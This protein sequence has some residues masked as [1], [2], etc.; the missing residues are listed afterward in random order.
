[1]RAPQL[2]SH[3][4]C[5]PERPAAPAPVGER[6]PWAAM[7]SSAVHLPPHHRDGGYCPAVSRCAGHAASLSRLVHNPQP[8]RTSLG[9]WVHTDP[10]EPWRGCTDLLPGAKCSGGT[11]RCGLEPEECRVPAETC[12]THR[13]AGSRGGGAPLTSVPL[14]D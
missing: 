9:P 11:G 4:H 2:R 8:V 3:A 7:L 14:R 13:L 6:G 5:S 12:C 1:M 10:P